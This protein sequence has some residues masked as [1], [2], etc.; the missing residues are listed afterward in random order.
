VGGY[1]LA[2]Y[3]HPALHGGSGF[4]GQNGSGLPPGRI[5]L[6]TSIDGVDFVACYPRRMTVPVD[7]VAFNFRL[8]W[9]TRESGEGIARQ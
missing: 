6:L 8:T 3:G 9:R 7:G 2:A 4:L 1:A 5:D